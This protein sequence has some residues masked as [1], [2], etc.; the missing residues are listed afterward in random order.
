[1][2]IP[3]EFSDITLT[4]LL[5]ELKMWSSELVDQVQLQQYLMVFGK[6]CLGQVSL[7][8]LI[9]FIHNFPEEIFILTIE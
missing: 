6:N 8:Y 9:H 3:F 5:N 4:Q 2:Q 1:M 7:N